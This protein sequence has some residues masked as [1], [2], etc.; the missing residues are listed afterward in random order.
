[1]H[2]LPF[3]KPGRF[4]RGNLHMHSTRSDGLLA[5]EAAVASYRRAG[6]DFVTLTDHFLDRYDFPI[7]DTS[8]W[9]DGEFTTLLG[10]E[11]HGPRLI[12]GERW[13]LLAVGLPPDFA[14][15]AEDE[16]GPA[17]AARAA[18][19]G[20]FVG[21]AHPSWY[22][23]AVE[24]A[25]TVEAAH[26]VEIYNETCAADSDRGESWALCDALLARG[27]RLLAFAS[28]DTHFR[29]ERPDT[30]GGWVQVKAER[31]EPAA[32]LAALKAGQFYAS[33]GPLIHDVRLDGD[34]LKVACSP[35][36]AIFVAGPRSLSARVHGAGLT[37]AGLSL[38]RFRE[39]KAAYCRVTVLDAAGR[40]AWTNPIWLE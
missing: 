10:A 23:L 33:Q 22:N 40:R 31:L 14:P 34:C 36:R 27:R 4:Y 20:A 1:M 35:A 16:T 3:D 19:A 21:L 39:Q 25:L 18:E 29:P 26:A 5:P 30:F 17:I 9:R 7:T 32:L 6:Y 11:L 8:A 12:N 24:D 38:E 2:S 13:H 15:A 37:A 28:D